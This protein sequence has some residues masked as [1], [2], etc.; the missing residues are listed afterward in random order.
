VDKRPDYQNLY[1]RA[2]DLYG[3]ITKKALENEQ[4]NK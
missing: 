3:Q 2:V 1:S 4:A